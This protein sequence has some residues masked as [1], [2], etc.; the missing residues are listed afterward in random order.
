MLVVREPFFISILGKKKALHN[1]SQTADGY[2]NAF[3]NTVAPLMTLGAVENVT[4]EV[5]VS[6][7]LRWVF[8]HSANWLQSAEIHTYTTTMVGALN[9]GDDYEELRG[10]EDASGYSDDFKDGAKSVPAVL[11]GYITQQL[12]S[13]GVKI[14][15][16]FNMDVALMIMGKILT[17]PILQTVAASLPADATAAF[18][19]LETIWQKQ[20]RISKGA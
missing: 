7:L 5:L 4:L 1:M 16:F 9:F 2:S 3:Y 18:L 12:R 13:E 20:R 8:G 11:L 17:R 15:A 6:Q 14:P 19:V 10:K